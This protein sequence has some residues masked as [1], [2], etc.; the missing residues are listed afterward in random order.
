[1]TYDMKVIILDLGW[2]NLQAMQQF[3]VKMGNNSKILRPEVSRPLK[4][5]GSYICVIPGIGSA[6]QFNKISKS[7]R[8]VILEI[9]EK[10][11]FTFGICLGAHFLTSRTEEFDGIGLNLIDSSV[12]KI[13]NNFQIGY[14]NVLFQA[15]K[16]LIYHCH[17]YYIPVI[18]NTVSKGQL[19]H[20]NF[21][22][23]LVIENNVCLIQG[24]PE[25]SGLDGEMLIGDIL[26]SRCI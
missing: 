2:G 15:K 16:Y 18:K 1:M 11:N 14:R 9:V 19:S 8:C 3:F 25:K 24:H 22:S 12:L 13:K 20:D 17:S 21:Y 10:A 5:L 23:H 6:S 4:L 26:R 7:L